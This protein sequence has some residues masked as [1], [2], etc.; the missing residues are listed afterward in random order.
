MRPVARVDG[1]TVSYPGVRALDGV[2]FSV[3]GG[4][5]LGIIGPNGAGKSTLFAC[6]LGLIGSYGGRIEFFGR[7]VRESRA[8]LRDVGYVPQ[9]PAFESNFP[10]TVREVVRMGA[11]RGLGEGAVDRALQDVWMHELAGRRIGELSG[12]QLQRVF[13]AKALVNGPRVMILDEPVTGVDHRSSELFYGILQDLNRRKGMAIIWSSHD[14][15]AISR[16]A[17]KVACLNRTLAFHVSADEFRDDEALA[18]QYT[19]ASM[20]E[21]VRS[22]G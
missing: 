16:L 14:M 21:H 5:I 19:E 9:R 22:H 20:Q 10:A 7:D 18:R 12:G 3:D 11:R 1:L 6:M 15:D 8:Y 17:T 13:I 4:D 2:S